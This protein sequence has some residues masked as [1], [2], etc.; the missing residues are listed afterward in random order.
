MLIKVVISETQNETVI[1]MYSLNQEGFIPQPNTV[2]VELYFS[3]MKIL[4]ESDSTL[5]TFIMQIDG[6]IPS[7]ATKLKLAY[8]SQWIG[9]FSKAVQEY[10]RQKQVL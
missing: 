3:M 5:M 1:V 9:K 8:L 2:K 6:K 7:S 10:Q 4:E